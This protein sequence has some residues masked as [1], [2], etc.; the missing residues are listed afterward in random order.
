MRTM[1]LLY[2]FMSGT[3]YSEDMLYEINP[4]KMYVYYT[5]L[6]WTFKCG[7]L[8]NKSP[9]FIKSR[10]IHPSHKPVKHHM[11]FRNKLA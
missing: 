10:E 9:P 8:F 5:R 3:A 2:E 1:Q 7:L 6:N 11:R 4:G